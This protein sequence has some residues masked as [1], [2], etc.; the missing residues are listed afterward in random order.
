MDSCNIV[1]DL[2]S[3]NGLGQATYPL[4]SYN[5][6]MYLAEIYSSLPE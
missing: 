1:Y 2:K 6:N 5:V 3:N 4:M